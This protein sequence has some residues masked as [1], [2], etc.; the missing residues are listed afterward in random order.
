ML[1]FGEWR[2]VRT[3][4]IIAVVI[5][6]EGLEEVHVVDF[7]VLGVPFHERGARSPRCRPL[8]AARPCPARDTYVGPDCTVEASEW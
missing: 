4:A 3:N 6:V 2:W 8:A 1:L 5:T 7:H